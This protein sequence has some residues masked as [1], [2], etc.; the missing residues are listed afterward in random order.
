MAWARIDPAIGDLDWR[1]YLFVTRDRRAYFGGAGAESRL[2]AWVDRLMGSSMAVAALDGDLRALPGSD[3]EQLFDVVRDRVLE[4]EDKMVAPAGIAGLTVLTKVHPP[5]QRRLVEMLED[6][7]RWSWPVGGAG[8]DDVPTEA[9][10]RARWQ[11]LTDK[12]ADQD[13]NQALRTVAQQVRTLPGA[14]RGGR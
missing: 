13:G 5:C 11:A 3:I 4:A 10:V 2:D 1:P 7:A 6:L 12:W 9:G 8:L 14:S